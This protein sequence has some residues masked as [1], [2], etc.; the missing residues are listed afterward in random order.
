M[1]RQKLFNTINKSKF[2]EKR[3][4]DKTNRKIAK[5][6]FKIIFLEDYSLN[7]LL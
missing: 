3:E 2:Q 5:K 4:R 7:P 6:D 1:M